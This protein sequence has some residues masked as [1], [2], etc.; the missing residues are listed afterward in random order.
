MLV[1]GGRKTPWKPENPLGFVGELHF[2][3]LLR[4]FR[5]P[6]SKSEDPCILRGNGSTMVDGSFSGVGTPAGAHPCVEHRWTLE[7]SISL[8]F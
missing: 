1:G 3:H 7:L 2:H 5:W 4:Y 8:S 6:Y